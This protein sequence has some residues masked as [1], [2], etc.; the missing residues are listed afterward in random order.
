MSVS[1]YEL[2]ADE[3]LRVWNVGHDA[4]GI[5]QCFVS[6]AA[7]TVS[8]AATVIVSDRSDSLTD[9]SRSNSHGRQRLSD[10]QNIAPHSTYLIFIHYYLSLSLVSLVAFRVP[11]FE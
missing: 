7:G 2:F 5:Y 6:N 4:S 3:G 11:F 9:P 1:V 10:L 8:A